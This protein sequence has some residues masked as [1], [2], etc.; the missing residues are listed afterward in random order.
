MSEGEGG[1]GGLRAP[2]SDSTR[3]TGRGGQGE[4]KGAGWRSEG[5]ARTPPPGS[6]WV[7]RGYLDLPSGSAKDSHSED[8]CRALLMLA[9][10]AQG[11]EMPHDMGLVAVP[12]T[13][14]RGA[15]R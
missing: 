10:S 4:G 13:H 11:L 12:T 2:P 14:W 6:P 7:L 9:R 5:G 8:F 15:D 3:G 1:K